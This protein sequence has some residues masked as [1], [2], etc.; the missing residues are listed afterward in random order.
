MASL[1]L[2]SDP[3]PPLPSDRRTSLCFVRASCFCAPA[4]PAGELVTLGT[5]GGEGMDT[6]RYLLVLS[7]QSNLWGWVGGDAHFRRGTQKG[8]AGGQRGGAGARREAQQGIATLPLALP[9]PP[10]KG[11]ASLLPQHPDLG[12][13]TPRFHEVRASSGQI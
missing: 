5:G 8:A 10:L 13:S 3:L 4:R 2:L 9:R 11:L 1:T 7:L 6:P 12:L